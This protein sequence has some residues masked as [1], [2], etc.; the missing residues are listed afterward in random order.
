MEDVDG[1]DKP[2]HDEGLGCRPL[3]PL[4]TTGHEREARQAGQTGQAEQAQGAAAARAGR[5]HTWRDHRDAAVN[6]EVYRVP[7]DA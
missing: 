1:R 4:I 6:R 7:F 3:F 2:G 5:S